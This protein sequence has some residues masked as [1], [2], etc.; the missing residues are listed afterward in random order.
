MK[1]KGLS[2]IFST[3]DLFVLIEWGR[4]GQGRVSEFIDS[5]K[6]SRFIKQVMWFFVFQFQSYVVAIIIPDQETLEPWAQSKKI[7][8]NFANLCEN[9]VRMHVNCNGLPQPA[10]RHEVVCV[11]YIQTILE[12]VN[13]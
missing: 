10:I 4:I 13:K 9:E 11:A 12:K 2:V 1:F 6:G 7:P 8:G 5:L 3:S